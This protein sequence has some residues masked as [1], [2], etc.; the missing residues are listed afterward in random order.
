MAIPFLV[1][2]RGALRDRISLFYAVVIPGA[3][4]LIL[5]TLFPSPGYRQQLIAGTL[6]T[7][8]LFFC[9]TGV[10]FESLALRNQG[11]YKLLRATPFRT[12]DF[13]SILTAARGVVALASAL[14][15]GAIGLVAF[16]ILPPMIGL[17]SI[18]PLLVLATLTFTFL[19]LAISNFAQ[20]EGQVSM[21]TNLVT[22][23]MI[24]ASE[25]F[26]RLDGAPAWVRLI[27]RALPFGY[28]IDGVR[29]G[30]AGDSPGVLKPTLILAASAI[31]ALAISIVT[32]R[33]DPAAVPLRGIPGRSEAV[34]GAP[35]PDLT[36]RGNAND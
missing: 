4:L 29:A 20:N 12:I 19:G 32:F 27:E 28:L 6:A 35:D 23:P 22:L 2:L 15:V 21:L 30:L 10:A 24:L 34:K 26:Y 33:W 9:C 11:V 7:S 3:L 25:A 18:L 13:A 1:L 16:G 14:I 17:L 36:P 8:L 31:L 5:G